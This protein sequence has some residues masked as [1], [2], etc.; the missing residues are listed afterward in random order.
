MGLRLASRKDTGETAPAAAE[1]AAPVAAERPAARAPAEYP[2]RPEI[3][4]EAAMMQFEDAHIIAYLNGITQGALPTHEWVRTGPYYK[5]YFDL[6]STGE[7]TIQQ[8]WIGSELPEEAFSRLNRALKFPSLQEPKEI[9]EAGP[10]ALTM[11]FSHSARSE[12][13]A[14]KP[15][16]PSGEPACKPGHFH[17]RID[18]GVPVTFEAVSR[19]L[20]R[21]HEVIIDDQTY[22]MR[23][24]NLT[25][26]QYHW[27]ELKAAVD[28]EFAAPA[29][30]AAPADS[31]PSI[32][33]MAAGFTV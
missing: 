33:Q 23:T 30:P 27:H 3:E 10:G 22:L 21:Q 8:K 20:P 12:S 24:G 28:R 18:T 15:I 7:G 17:A 19:F 26:L 1:Q 11:F 29:A 6:V 2:Y 16:G 4:T 31:G 13:E 32:G 5:S 14:A 9:V 25:Y